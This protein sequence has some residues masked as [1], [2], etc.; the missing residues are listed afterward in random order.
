MICQYVACSATKTLQEVYPAMTTV[1]NLMRSPATFT[2]PRRYGTPAAAL[3]VVLLLGLA[4]AES[5]AQEESMLLDGVTVAEGSIG[6][7]ALSTMECFPVSNF[8]L[9]G[10]TITVHTSHW[11]RRATA[12]DAWEDLADTEVTGQ[13]CPLSPEEPGDYRMIIDGTIDG[14]RGMFH[15][16]HFTKTAADPV[17]VLPGYAA[18]WLAL[19]LAGLALRARRSASAP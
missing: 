10:S 7:G 8:T 16:T 17:P 4:A 1:L 13:V 11:Q 18:V 3:L 6:L 2:A 5:H 12:D 15:T 14:E 19:L 9:G